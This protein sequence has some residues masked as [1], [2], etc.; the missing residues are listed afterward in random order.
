M[1][2]GERFFTNSYLYSFFLYFLLCAIIDY[3]LL[4]F[5]V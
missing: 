3:M 4:L 5:I 1:A 2:L